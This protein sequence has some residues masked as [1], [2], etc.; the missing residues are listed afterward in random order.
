[1]TRFREHRGHLE[2]SLATETTIESR[3]QLLAYANKILNPYGITVDDSM[4][5]VM[6]YYGDEE[7]T[8]WR[9]LHIVAIDGYGAFGFIEGEPR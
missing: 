9:D 6:P 8:G 4:L 1:M 2:D 3:A 7:R 5:R